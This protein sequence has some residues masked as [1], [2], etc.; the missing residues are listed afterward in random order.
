[1]MNLPVALS[2]ATSD[3]G[4]GAGVQADLLTFAACQTYGI[5][6]FAALTAQNPNGVSAIHELPPEFLVN[7]LNQLAEYYP[8]QAAKTGMLFS[9]PLIEATAD[10][11]RK[12][13]LKVVVDPVMVAT[14]GARLLQDNAISCLKEQLLPLATVITPNLDEAAV[15]LGYRPHTADE[16]R[17]AAQELTARF[18]A[19]TL[20][21]GGHLPGNALLDILHLPDG[22]QHEILAQRIPAVDTHGSGCTL[23]AAIAAH[24]ARGLSLPSAVRA[25]HAYLKNGLQ[26]PLHVAGKAFIRH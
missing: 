3:S 1:M 14:S 26:N 17:Q 22:G 10:F 12:K 9:A 2:I 24:L 4:C 11:I 21:K 20:L 19:A 25:G 6:A 8:I 5:T 18:G 13:Q 23:S 16:M 7:Q 15:L